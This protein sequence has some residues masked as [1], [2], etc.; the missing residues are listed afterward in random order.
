MLIYFNLWFYFDLIFRLWA[1]SIE[2]GNS[3]QDSEHNSLYCLFGINLV[4]TEEGMKNL[5]HVCNISNNISDLLTI[6]LY[7]YFDTW[8]YLHINNRL[9]SHSN[10]EY[11]HLF[12]LTI[13]KIIKFQFEIGFK[14]KYQILLLQVLNAIFSYLALI[15]E[16]GVTE[17]IF[18]DMK[19][20]EDMNFQ[21]M[22]ES[23]PV[24]NVEEISANMQIYPPKDYLTGP[25]L[26]FEYNSDYIIQV[27]NKLSPDSVNII[28]LD[29]TLGDN[30]YNQMEPWFS[31][32]Y[33]SKG[34]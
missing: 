21:Y 27:L 17:K 28:I 15:K 2:A 20:L 25:D 18:N 7:K 14:T 22:E 24:D 5:E 16:K 6:Y 26:M 12:K 3:E 30:I 33:V 32:R 8:E 19:L 31:T 4:L 34:M 1:V 9:Y 23:E 11:C 29:S 10:R 13:F